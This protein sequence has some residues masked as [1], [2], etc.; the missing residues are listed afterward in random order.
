[1]HETSPTLAHMCE[2]EPPISTVPHMFITRLKFMELSV[3]IEYFQ[4]D[5]LW[6]FRFIDHRDPKDHQ[7]LL[8]SV[9]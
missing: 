7:K 6:E 9:P 8:L 2:L 5:I 4:E 1:M 3:G